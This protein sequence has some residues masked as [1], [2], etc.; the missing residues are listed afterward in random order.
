MKYAT[1]VGL[2]AMLAS[3]LA[4]GGCASTSETAS[5][6]S[7]ESSSAKKKNVSVRGDCEQKTGSR[8]SKRC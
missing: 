5:T 4:L 1:R 8:L 7:A 3:V 6:E 2:A